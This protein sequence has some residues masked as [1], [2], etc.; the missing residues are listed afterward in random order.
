[1]AG[2]ILIVEDNPDNLRL[3][4]WMLEDENREFDA[5]VTGEACLEQLHKEK[6]A[7]VLLDIS[8]P[9]ID[10]KETTR[11][12]RA[13]PQFRSLPIIA[14]TA[15]AIKQEEVEI[16]AAGVNSIVTKPIEE[17]LLLDALRTYLGN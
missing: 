8:L 3:V 7:L 1:M 6:Y 9:G 10:G 15:H 11:R 2:K 4:S 5:V 14:C 12:I 16:L 17:K 13:Q